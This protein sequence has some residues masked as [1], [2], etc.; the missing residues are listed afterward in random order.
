MTNS[1]SDFSTVK[2]GGTLYYMSM[3]CKVIEVNYI[4]DY[5]LRCELSNATGRKLAFSIHGQEYID[6]PQVLFWSDPHVVAPPRPRRLVK[7]TMM[8]RPFLN[9]VDYDGSYLID[10]VCKGLDATNRDWCGPIQS[11]EIE[12]EEE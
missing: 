3:P 5:P 11:I 2:I 8:V 12:V 6:G 10:I 4:Q 9:E 7:K 1:G